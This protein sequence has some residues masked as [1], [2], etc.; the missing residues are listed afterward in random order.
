ML[1]KTLPSRVMLV[2]FLLVG[3]CSDDKDYGG[4]PTHD[5]SLRDRLLDGAAADRAPL[6]DRIVNPEGPEIT[7][8]EPVLGE[9]V[10]GNQMEVQARIVDSDSDVDPSSVVAYVESDVL[11]SLGRDAEAQDVYKGMVNIS[12]LPDEQAVVVVQAADLNGNINSAEVT[13][14]RDKGPRITFFT[15][16]ADQYYAGSVLLQF[17]V[18]DSDGVVE[19][20]VSANIG[21]VTLPAHKI[22]ES[23][24][25][26][27]HF[28]MYSYEIVFQDAMFDPALKGT[29][30]IRV[31]ARNSNNTATEAT[32]QFVVDEEGPQ[33]EI[34]NPL[35]GDLVGGILTIQAEVTDPAEVN[36]SSVVA[37]LGGNVNDYYIELS[38]ISGLYQANFD[39]RVFPDTFVYPSI[40]VRAADMLGNENEVGHQFILDNRSPIISLDP[41]VDFRLA[42]LNSEGQM[43]CSW[44][45]DPVGTD[46]ADYGDV[47]PQIFWLRARIEDQGNRAQ[48]L[49]YQHVSL[50]NPS[51]VKLYILDDTTYPLVLD[52]DG[53][54]FCDEM[55]PELV[56]TTHPQGNNEVLVLNMEA[57]PPTG[58]ARFT[59]EPDP[60]FPPICSISGPE[61]DPPEPLCLDTEMT[62]AIFYGIDHTQPAIYSLPP[63]VPPDPVGVKC[64]GLQFDSLANNISEGWACVAVRAEDYL[65]NIGISPPLAVCVDYE[66]DGNPSV[67]SQ[68]PDPASFCLGTQDPNTLEISSTPCIFDGDK[69]LFLS[70]EVRRIE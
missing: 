15:P 25:D 13:F 57:I 67:C 12:D 66:L 54:G 38:L 64:T 44:E 7:I 36:P 24:E 65:G 10:A 26:P 49:T 14:Q 20:S 2:I 62:V 43:E 31:A 18:R 37:V 46:A 16:V 8:L 53:D 70:R 33:I 5:A 40:T 39:T 59:P 50:V 4:F 51:T 47:V 63:I 56:P 21:S 42:S 23:G 48:G 45:F 19:S 61:T 58:E 68:A 30:M 1:L 41:P 9:V 3:A 29:Q 52:T 11:F 32:L 35:A 17:E 55:N 69:Q 60:Q 28:L 34:V 27:P 22:D 6:T